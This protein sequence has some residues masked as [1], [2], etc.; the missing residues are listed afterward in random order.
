MKSFWKRFKPQFK[1]QECILNNKYFYNS[2]KCSEYFRNYFFQDDTTFKIEANLKVAEISNNE[3]KKS[4]K[5]TAVIKDSDNEVTVLNSNC[6]EAVDQAK[7][8]DGVP[9]T[10][11]ESQV[12]VT[13]PTVE[14]KPVQ[15]VNEVQQDTAVSIA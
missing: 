3:V 12:E 13:E 9:E 11:M 6:E 1:K 10:S 15:L 8:S 7:Q 5:C 14:R 2:V 4:L